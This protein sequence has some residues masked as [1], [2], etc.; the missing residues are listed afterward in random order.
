MDDTE[1]TMVGTNDVC[2][3]VG[4]GVGMTEVRSAVQG[5][6]EPDGVSVVAGAQGVVLTILQDEVEGGGQGV[7]FGGLEGAPRAEQV[8]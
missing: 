5:M 7:G 1:G 4:V 3:R 6:E 8:D 2:I